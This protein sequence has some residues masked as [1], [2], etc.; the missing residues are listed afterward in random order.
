MDTLA[1][2]RISA[3]GTR[4]KPNQ[5]WYSQALKILQRRYRQKER[6]WKLSPCEAERVDLKLALNSYKEACR[7]AKSDYF[8]RKI[9]EAANSSRELFRTVNVLTTSLGTPKVENSQDFCNKVATFF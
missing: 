7:V 1:P 3:P 6:C 5:P 2:G 4:K 8:T 9:S